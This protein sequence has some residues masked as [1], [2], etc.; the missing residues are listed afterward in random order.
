MRSRLMMAGF[1][2]SDSLMTFEFRWVRDGDGSPP[3]AEDADAGAPPVGVFELLA[4][5]AARTSS[6]ATQVRVVM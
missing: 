5:E 2:N 3:V 4:H 1:C 6:A